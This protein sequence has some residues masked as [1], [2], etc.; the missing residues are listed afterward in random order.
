MVVSV[1][2]VTYNSG[3]AVLD[4]L[5]SVYRHKGDY[6]LK[7]Y[8]SDNNS[9][10]DALDRVR[11]E[12]PQVMII[13]NGDNLGFGHGHNMCIPYLDSDYHFVV[14]PDII[15]QDDIF[16]RMTEYMEANPDIVMAVP[17][18]LSAEGDVQFTPKLAPKIR[19]MVGG[20]FERFGGIFRKWRSEYTMRDHPPA[21]TVDVSF[22]SGCFM[23][24]RT[25]VF[26]DMGGFDE[27]Y[28]LYNEDADI[29]RMAQK[30]GRTVYTPQFSVVHLWDRA[31][32]RKHRYFFIQIDSLLKYLW[33]WRMGGKYAVNIHRSSK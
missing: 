13:E 27:R 8:I 16:G 33:K 29:T 15:L 9:S 1:C 32:M 20:R 6:E 4:M 22:C 25:S 19:Y 21:D 5:R 14:N 10:D 28:F 18:Y 7:V 31:Y 23:A 2:A 26:R 24:V 11:K 12:F 17:K 3:D 30:Y